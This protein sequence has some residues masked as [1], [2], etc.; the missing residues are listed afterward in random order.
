MTLE[1]YVKCKRKELILNILNNPSI[2]W[3]WNSLSYNGNI[4]WDIV[5]A[6]LD[7]PWVG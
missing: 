2:P 7:K 5:Q 4:T 3:D 1:S 6:N